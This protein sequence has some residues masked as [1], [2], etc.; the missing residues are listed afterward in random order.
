MH[1]NFL[2]NRQMDGQTGR[3]NMPPKERGELVGY[4]V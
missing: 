2:M 3:N 1:A 4:G